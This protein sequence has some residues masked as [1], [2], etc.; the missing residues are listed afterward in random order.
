MTFFGEPLRLRFHP[1]VVSF[2]IVLKLEYECLV[3]L[4]LVLHTVM[5]RLY[6]TL[7]NVKDDH[8][9]SLLQLPTVMLLHLAL[10]CHTSSKQKAG[11]KA[12]IYS[13]ESDKGLINVRTHYKRKKWKRMIYNF[14]LYNLYIIS[15]YVICVNHFLKLKKIHYNYDVYLIYCIKV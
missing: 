11:K 6:G 10:R 3:I 7:V 2:R 13:K 1:P 14:D 15:M 8:F 9:V 4:N 12:K 5:I